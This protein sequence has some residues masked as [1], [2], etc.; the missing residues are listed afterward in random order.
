VREPW[1]KAR[2][3]IGKGNNVNAWERKV[4]MGENKV[5]KG[6][7]HVSVMCPRWIDACVRGFMHMHE[8][9]EKEW[10]KEK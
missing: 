1:R 5:N 8:E 3:C 2:M 10:E 6:D 4:R 7:A 9:R